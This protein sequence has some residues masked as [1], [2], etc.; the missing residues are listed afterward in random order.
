MTGITTILSMPIIVKYILLW[1]PLLFLAVLNGTMREKVIKGR[2]G[3]LRAHQFSTFTFLLLLSLYLWLTTAF[4]P[5][6]S[7]VQCLEMGTVWLILTLAFEFLFM[8][9][10]FKVPYIRLIH[11]YKIWEGRIWVLVLVW[12][13]AA[14]S[15]IYYLMVLK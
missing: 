4:W 13:L 3:D 12:V 6:E 10:V 15:L 2:L 1:L 11:D 8:H 14:P 5:P 7:L 9:F